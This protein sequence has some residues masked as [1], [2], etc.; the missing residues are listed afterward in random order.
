MEPP[1]HVFVKSD[2]LE[3]Q[4]IQDNVAIDSENA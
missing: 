4:N 1:R 2:A 3:R